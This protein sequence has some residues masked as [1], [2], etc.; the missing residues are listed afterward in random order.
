[1]KVRRGD[2]VYFCCETDKRKHIYGKKR[3][4][5]IVSNDVGN[6]YSDICLCVP[7]STSLK[8]LD[9]PT[10]TVIKTHKWDMCACE[11]IFTFS[12]D[13]VECIAFHLSET[14]MQNVN[15]CLKV[16]LELG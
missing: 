8:R 4:Y 13:D 15:K 6:W 10:H 14:D 9:L 16:A 2:I 1:M 12:Q 3:P 11:Q 7:L 5:L